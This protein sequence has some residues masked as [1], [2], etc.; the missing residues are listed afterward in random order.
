MTEKQKIEFGQMQ[1]MFFER[2]AKYPGDKES[3]MKML[4]I[5]YDWIDKQIDNELS[6]TL[7]ANST[8]LRGNAI[9]GGK[10]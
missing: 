7:G 6:K 9:K 3:L 1:A 8:L 10:A 4:E 2:M 5:F